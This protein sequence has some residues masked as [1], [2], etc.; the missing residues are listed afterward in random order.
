MFT[1]RYPVC[2]GSLEAVVSN[3]ERLVVRACVRACVAS[4]TMVY[5]TVCVN[6]HEIMS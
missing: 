2:C 3:S 4:G 6:I 1:Y 5:G